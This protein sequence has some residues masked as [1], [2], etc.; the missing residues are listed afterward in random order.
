[1]GRWSGLSEKK[2]W[3]ALPKETA[4]MTNE[5]ERFLPRSRGNTATSLTFCAG[6]IA[7]SL[8]VSL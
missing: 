7:E 2:C 6:A 3:T 1:M 4:F 5:K 8:S